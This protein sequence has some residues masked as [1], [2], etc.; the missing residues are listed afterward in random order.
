MHGP[1]LMDMD[2]IGTRNMIRLVVHR[3]AM[4]LPTTIILQRKM[5]V[6]TAAVVIGVKNNHIIHRFL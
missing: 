4:T 1:T 2:A 3:L 5:R 6:V